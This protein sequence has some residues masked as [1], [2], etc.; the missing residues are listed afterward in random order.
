MQLAP[1]PELF[2][3]VFGSPSPPPLALPPL[4]TIMAVLEQAAARCWGCEWVRQPL[5]D[6]EWQQVVQRQAAYPAKVLKTR[7]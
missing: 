2:T 3:Q 4:G 1:D 6:Q 7:A 5:S